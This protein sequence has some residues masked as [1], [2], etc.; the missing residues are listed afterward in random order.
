METISESPCEIDLFN[1]LPAQDTAG[2]AYDYFTKFSGFCEEVYYLLEVATRESADPDEV[3]KVSQEVTDQ[4]SQA[5]V[6]NFENKLETDEVLIPLEELSFDT[7]KGDEQDRDI[8][9]Q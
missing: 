8:P 3:V 6:Y 4:R 9:Q 1:C 7:L 2:T 5:L